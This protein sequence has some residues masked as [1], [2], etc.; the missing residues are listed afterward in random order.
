MIRCTMLE[1][2][3]LHRRESLPSH[4]YLLTICGTV[5][6]WCELHFRCA[7][8]RDRR[9]ILNRGAPTAS[10]RVLSSSAVMIER[11]HAETGR[12]PQIKP[13]LCPLP[14]SRTGR[15]LTSQC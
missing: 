12:G 5:L 9:M 1:S 7:R 4:D 14:A 10:G 15:E 2:L 11:R 6:T 8:G 3:A 13:L